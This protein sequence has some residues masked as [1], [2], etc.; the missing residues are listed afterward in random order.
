[1]G[2]I[3]I[4]RINSQNFTEFNFE[5]INSQ[6]QEAQWIPSIRNLKKIYT[7]RHIIIELLKA[8]DK[9]ETLKV[10]RAGRQNK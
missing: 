9:E 6:I 7:P 8:S 2:D 1:M 3:A 4:Y 10:A 5:S